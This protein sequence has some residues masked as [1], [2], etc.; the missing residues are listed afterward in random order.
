MPLVV[1]SD[2]LG[3]RRGVRWLQDDWRRHATIR[4]LNRLSDHELNDVGIK[5]SDIALIA[6]EMVKQWREGHPAV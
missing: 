5:R 2:G 1:I 6:D 4:E 3:V